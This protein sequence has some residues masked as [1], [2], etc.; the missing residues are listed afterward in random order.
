MLIIQGFFF[1][2]E[3][4]NVAHTSLSMCLVTLDILLNPAKNQSAICHLY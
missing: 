2:V 3:S 1:Q 4:K